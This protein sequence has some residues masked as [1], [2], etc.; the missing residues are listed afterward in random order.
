MKLTISIVVLALTVLGSNVYA[1]AKGPKA[2]SFY[3]L[4]ETYR[5][6]CTHG[7]IAPFKS[8]TAFNVDKP[9]QSRLTSN[10]EKNLNRVAYDQ[11]QVWAD[12]ILEGDYYADGQTR[13]D[14]VIT[15]YKNDEFIGYKIAYSERA[16]FTG[17]CDF[18]DDD[19]ALRNCQEGRIQEST[20]VSPDFKTF[21]RDDD[22]LADFAG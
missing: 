12:T 8:E 1:D 5:Q 16:W 6:A 9:S 3:D 11:A 7:C 21:F 17:D 10:V 13:L 14:S 20:Y 2:D 22:A 18:N 4:I 15:L 19:A